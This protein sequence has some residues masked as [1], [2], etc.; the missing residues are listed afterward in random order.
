MQ[1]R[2]FKG[3][4]IP[5]E[6]YLCTELS[7]VEKILFAE[8][9]SLDNENHCTASNEYFAEFCQCS[10]PTISRAIK[11]L[12][13]LNLIEEDKFNGRNR[14]IKMINQ[15]NHF[16]E[17][18][19]SKCSTINIYNNTKRKNNSIINNTTKSTTNSKSKNIYQKCSDEI[20]AK[21]FS[22]KLQDVLHDYL[23]VRLKMTDKPI[24]TTKQ[25][26]G[27]LNR[28]EELEPNVESVQ[29]AIVKQSIER[30]WASFFP[31]ADAQKPSKKKV[32][33]GVSC[34]QYTEKEKVEIKKYQKEVMKNG[35]RIKF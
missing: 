12:K 29:I 15:P 18:A 26:A 2:D 22:K 13:E 8:I 6:I 31:L 17:A 11:H 5:K 4:W 33:K 3:V 28:L 34:E 35:G 24:Y 7:A 19:L 21:N 20:K 32:D 14:I 9:S 16:D 10:I 25:W 1:E 27:I 30:G 23:S